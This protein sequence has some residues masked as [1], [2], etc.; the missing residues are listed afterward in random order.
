MVMTAPQQKR[1][2]SHEWSHV[3]QQKLKKYKCTQPT[4]T[5][6]PN[7]STLRCSTANR[8]PSPYLTLMKN[9]AAALTAV[10]LDVRQLPDDGAIN[11]RDRHRLLHPPRVGASQTCHPPTHPAHLSSNLV[12]IKEWW[13]KP[14][15]ARFTKHLSRSPCR[16]FARSLAI[17]S[18]ATTVANTSPAGAGHPVSNLVVVNRFSLLRDHAPPYVPED[19]AEISE[20]KV[21][22]A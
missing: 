17:S 20:K 8:M 9:Y 1:E 4:R 18:W 12:A 19:N 11:Q 16:S 10:K 14:R 21:K 7:T 13:P 22:T 2:V 15:K 5:F 6:P 3:L